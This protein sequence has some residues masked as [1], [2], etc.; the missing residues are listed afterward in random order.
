MKIFDRLL[1]ESARSIYPED[2]LIGHEESTF[3]RLNFGKRGCLPDSQHATAVPWS[4]EGALSMASLDY[5]LRRRRTSSRAI[6]RV[7]QDGAEV[8]Y[9]AGSP[10]FLDRYHRSPEFIY[11]SF[12]HCVQEW[13]SVT[14]GRSHDQRV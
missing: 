8:T 4:P 7:P 11:P 3:R 14:E 1:Q 13:E 12:H 5:L 9:P 6:S 10:S 2:A